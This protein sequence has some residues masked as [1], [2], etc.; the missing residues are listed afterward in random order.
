[1]VENL[2]IKEKAK[3]STKSWARYTPEIVNINAKTPNKL[4]DSLSMDYDANGTLGIKIPAR[5]TVLLEVMG[6]AAPSKNVKIHVYG[7]PPNKKY[8]KLAEYHIDDV[9]TLSLHKYCLDIEP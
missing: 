1:M 6:N 4:T 2:W 7:T 5:S 9:K 3:T 8:Q